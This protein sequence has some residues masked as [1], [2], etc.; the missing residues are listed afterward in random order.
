MCSRKMVC[1]QLCKAGEFDKLLHS[2]DLLPDY[3]C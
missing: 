1:I 3:L 2:Y